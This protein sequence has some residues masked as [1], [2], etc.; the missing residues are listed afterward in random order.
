MKFVI[1]HGTMGS[2][3][4]NWFPWLAGEL[5]KLGQTTIRPRLP[6][7]RGQNPEKWTEVIKKAIESIGGPDQEIVVVAHSMSPWASCYYLGDIDRQIR[8]AFFV[9]PFAEQIEKE[10][11]FHSLIQ[12]FA[13]GK[14]DWNKVK[15][16][17][18]DIVC[19]V[20]DNDPYVSLAVAKR[21]QK[22]CSGKKLIIVPK[23]GHLNAESGHTKFPLLLE[24][25]REE[26]LI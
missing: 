26:L 1:L 19:F 9:S 8:A 22:L 4:G 20:G 24:T 17:C 6:T 11:P 10:E 2:P 7:P 18:K 14:V 25:I 5:K 13:D 3:E 12:P 16:N 15:K 21:F 23:G